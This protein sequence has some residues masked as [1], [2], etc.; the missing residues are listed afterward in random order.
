MGQWPSY[1]K[2]SSINL[3]Q[4]I[5]LNVPTGIRNTNKIPYFPWTKKI[6]NRWGQITMMSELECGAPWELYVETGG[7]ALLKLYLTLIAPS[8]IDIL[9]ARLNHS[10]NC[11][12]KNL[13]HDLEEHLPVP[14]PAARAFLFRIAGPIFLINWYFFLADSFTEFVFN[15]ESAVIQRQQCGPRPVGGPCQVS[16]GFNASFAVGSY[17][18]INWST[19]DNDP[20]NWT[21]GFRPAV[22]IAPQ[23]IASY[24]AYSSITFKNTNNSPVSAQLHIKQVDG[25]IIAVSSVVDVPPKG[26]A[27]T[28]VYGTVAVSNPSI[29]QFNAQFQLV[30]GTSVQA[31]GGSFTVAAL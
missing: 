3:G 26:S 20:S 16:N 1:I 10:Y 8:K 18:D 28:V 13:F 12:F 27:S 31:T 4:G 23:K 9:K 7:Q 21:H 29:A 17:R 30:S 11:G 19:V 5:R 2:G 14:N 22:T 6:L 15:W 25:T 24:K